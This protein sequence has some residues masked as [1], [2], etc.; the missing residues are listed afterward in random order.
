MPQ[1]GLLPFPGKRS[2]ERLNRRYGYDFGSQFAGGPSHVMCRRRAN[3][4][5]LARPRVGGYKRFVQSG[6]EFISLE[7]K[8]QR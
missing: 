2:R 5:R 8:G 3:F 4:F 6:R 1:S 7:R